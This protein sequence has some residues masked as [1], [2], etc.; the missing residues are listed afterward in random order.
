MRAIGRWCLAIA[1][2]GWLAGTAQAEIVVGVSLSL[3]GPAAAIGLAQRQVVDHLPRLVAGETL[4][5]EV[6]DDGSD[7]ARAAANAVALVDQ[8]GADAI[9]GSSTVAGTL[10]MLPVLAARGVVL[11]TPAAAAVPDDG[12]GRW[13]FRT[14]PDTR[15]MAHAVMAHMQAQ[16]VHR[17]AFMGADNAFAAGWA[18]WFETLALVRRIERVIVASAEP[19][20]LAEHVTAVTA[21]RPE[22][23]LIAAAGSHA[24][25]AVRALR[26]GGYAGRIYLTQAV[27]VD[28]FPG[29]CGSFCDGVF[30][31]AGPSRAIEG[32]R[33]EPASS[34]LA[35]VLGGRGLSQFE[36]GVWDAGRLLVAA[37]PEVIAK[38]APG[39]PAFRQGLRAAVE[40]L[41]ATPGANGVYRFSQRDHTGLD[42]QAAVM[43]RVA[44]GAW[45]LAR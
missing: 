8:A 9:I 33:L 26:E 4:R 15:I 39:S 16:D 11:M 32:G 35:G 5:Y 7:P 13:L 17:A 23:V 30:V 6:R 12:A 29:G 25:A 27:A 2:W 21:A 10:A 34:A 44:E 18:D 45:R 14:V 36:A 31:P 22:A 3:S 43:L 40:R 42:Q 38:A 41:P 20:A 1:A 28:G 24:I 37:M 19:E